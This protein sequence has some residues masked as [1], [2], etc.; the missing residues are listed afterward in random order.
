MSCL[1]QPTNLL[2]DE[3]TISSN[4]SQASIP[5]RS[6]PTTE[7]SS[8]SHT[9]VSLASTQDYGY[10]ADNEDS[11]DEEDLEDNERLCFPEQNDD[12][13]SVNTVSADSATAEEYLEATPHQ[14]QGDNP[15]GSADQ[16]TSDVVSS[17]PFTPG[18]EVDIEELLLDACE[19]RGFYW[20]T[21]DAGIR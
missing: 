13:T 6:W 14:Q 12:T 19:P 17:P 3:H 4:E 5:D 2:G 18:S 16:R 9:S 1:S 7:S 11:G 15:Q 20:K 10:E 21:S 8:T